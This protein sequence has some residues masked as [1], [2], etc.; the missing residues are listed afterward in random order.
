MILAGML[1]VS[2]EDSEKGREM[3][4]KVRALLSDSGLRTDKAHR[5]SMLEELHVQGSIMD[6]Q[7]ISHF[8]FRTAEYLHSNADTII[9]AQGETVE[10]VARQEGYESVQ[11]YSAK[12]VTGSR[13]K[14]ASTLALLASVSEA[15]I[16]VN[17]QQ[18]SQDNQSWRMH[19]KWVVGRPEQ[20]YRDIREE[21]ADI[22]VIVAHNHCD[23]L[24]PDMVR[25]AQGRFGCPFP[26]DV[27]DTEV[28]HPTVVQTILGT[29]QTVEVLED[30]TEQWDAMVRGEINVMRLFGEAI[31]EQD[32]RPT[33]A[34]HNVAASKGRARSTLQPYVRYGEDK[35]IDEVDR[36][37]LDGAS[38]W[39]RIEICDENRDEATR[40][41]IDDSF[42]LLLGVH[43]V[44]ATLLSEA[45]GP[46]MTCFLASLPDLTRVVVGTHQTLPQ[47]GL[48]C[49][50]RS[51]RPVVFKTTTYGFEKLDEVQDIKVGIGPGVTFRGSGDVDEVIDQAFLQ[52][53]MLAG[54]LARRKVAVLQIPLH[55]ANQ[56]STDRVLQCVIIGALLSHKELR[57]IRI[58]WPTAQ[59]H[60]GMDR[61]DFHVTLQWLWGA[62]RTRSIRS[63]GRLRS[64][65]KLFVRDQMYDGEIFDLSKSWTRFARYTFEIL[66]PVRVGQ[67]STH[68]CSDERTPRSVQQVRG[69]QA[70]GSSSDAVPNQEVSRQLLPIASPS[71]EEDSS[72]GDAFGDTRPQSRRQDHRSRPFEARP[73]LGAPWRP[74]TRREERTGRDTRDRGRNHRR[75]GSRDGVIA[76][77]ESI[78]KS[79]SRLLRHDIDQV[80]WHSERGDVE[81]PDICRWI[82]F[83]VEPAEVM[84]VARGAGQ[85]KTRFLLSWMEGHGWVVRCLGGH[86]REVDMGENGVPIELGDDHVE[87]MVHYTDLVSARQI[88][89]EGLKIGRL[90]PRMDGKQGRTHIH[91]REMRVYPR[92]DRD[93]GPVA[94]LYRVEE[95][96]YASISL[97]QNANRDILTE[98]INGV[99]DARLIY[100]IW[101]RSGH[102]I[103]LRT[104]GT[105]RRVDKVRIVV[106][107]FGQQVTLEMSRSTR[108]TDVKALTETAY[109]L[110]IGHLEWHEVWIKWKFRSAPEMRVQDNTTLQESLHTLGWTEDGGPPHLIA[111][112]RTEREGG[113]THRHDQTGGS[114][115][116][117]GGIGG[118]RKKCIKSRRDR[119]RT[120]FGGRA[121]NNILQTHLEEWQKNLL[122]FKRIGMLHEDVPSTWTV[123]DAIS[124]QATA[125]C[126]SDTS[127]TWRV[128]KSDAEATSGTEDPGGWDKYREVR[129][130]D[131]YW[132]PPYLP[133]QCGDTVLQSTTGLPQYCRIAEWVY[134]SAAEE[135]LGRLDY[136]I[137]GERLLRLVTHGT[138][139][140]GTTW[141]N[142]DT[143]KI[144]QATEEHG[145]VDRSGFCESF[146]NHLAQ[147]KHLLGAFLGTSGTKVQRSHNSK[148][149]SWM[150]DYVF[151]GCRFG[152]VPSWSAYT[153]YAV[154]SNLRGYVGLYDEILRILESKQAS[155]DIGI[156]DEH[157]AAAKNFSED[158]KGNICEMFLWIF[159]ELLEQE[160]LSEFQKQDGRDTPAVRVPAKM[161]VGL[162]FHSI[163]ILRV[164]QYRYITDGQ[165]SAAVP[166]GQEHVDW[167]EERI[168]VVPLSLRT[169]RLI[170]VA[171]VAPRY[172]QGGGGRPARRTPSSLRVS[173]AL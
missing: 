66:S 70:P 144:W 21:E 3:A 34:H 16:T 20:R 79:M 4:T 15:V 37:A 17:M 61:M 68:G 8:R 155:A 27:D 94:I 156:R 40:D 26:N 149:G 19:P 172:T 163:W 139:A 78:S 43:T 169:Q 77:Q 145:M 142:L 63:A 6:R 30:V 95:V 166:M 75:Y 59:D 99:V 46:H 72:T 97:L 130:E 104:R 24:L 41:S 140:A 32:I 48:A 112:F 54:E 82:R 137:L 102:S 10:E 146:A 74:H 49:F 96:L 5:A 115:L 80:P 110:P 109:G 117:L 7:L 153:K 114:L 12:M 161:W 100:D 14:E 170:V 67:G 47:S 168:G 29:V 23:I 38:L 39:G 56:T 126:G 173:V 134:H 51:Q 147:D 103:A 113:N 1:S 36:I 60:F 133:F 84:E 159:Y 98:G 71:G 143:Q 22:Q 135:T 93:R 129:I 150:G 124:V 131:G 2:L 171:G 86:S 90:V 92:L 11:A 167:G 64:F 125:G 73:C 58:V 138:T 9:S 119:A 76:R 31:V 45:Y 52:F 157:I 65:L 132:H 122:P 118:R 123:P 108:Y 154:V 120:Y 53:G 42:V 164:D 107:L 136:E 91:F 13:F 121:T 152:D 55:V 160:A 25:K 116:Q 162:F 165:P 87:F 89:V 88:E 62:I 33:L 57:R 151:T 35:D 69:G 101:D 44:A 141:K 148:L 28:A 83:F 106:E 50:G 128:T 127:E 18:F 111:T 85:G 158:D 105:A 81:V